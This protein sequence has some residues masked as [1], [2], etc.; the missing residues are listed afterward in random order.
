M[1]TY[2]LA[3]RRSLD[4]PEAFWAEAA[5]GIDWQKRWD[6]VQ[7]DGRWFVG[8]VLNTCHNAVDR[9]VAGGRGDQAAL[10]YDSPVTNTVKSYTYR[11]MQA[12]VARLGGALR[13]LGVGKGDRVIIYMPV[14]PQAVF[15]MLAC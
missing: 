12:E 11:E 7:G 6:K 2:E 3:Y 15:A 13:N 5:E 8:G 4:D 9:H 10:I 14:I 1:S